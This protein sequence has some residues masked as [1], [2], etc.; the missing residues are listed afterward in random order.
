MIPEVTMDQFID[1]I[2]QEF[3][4]VCMYVWVLCVFMKHSSIY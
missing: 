2:S 1:K 4:F 3:V